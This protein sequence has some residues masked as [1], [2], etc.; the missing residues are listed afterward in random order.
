MLLIH[1]CICNGISIAV[2]S[3]KHSH[4]YSFDF[5]THIHTYKHKHTHMCVYI[6]L[7]HLSRLIEIINKHIQCEFLHCL[8]LNRHNNKNN[9]DNTE[10]L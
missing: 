10:L 4:A 5:D 6:A 9:K 3:M 1:L 2:C 8:G 7:I